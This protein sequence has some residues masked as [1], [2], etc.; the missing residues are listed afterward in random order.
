MWI[1]FLHRANRNVS[2]VFLNGEIGGWY[3]WRVKTHVPGVGPL[4]EVIEVTLECVL[5]VCGYHLT[6]NK[7]IISKKSYRGAW[8][9]RVSRYGKN[10][11]RYIAIHDNRITI[12]IAIY[13]H[14]ILL[15]KKRPNEHRNSSTC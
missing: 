10:V 5:I 14:G 11:L 1:G 12:R 9:L 13:C 6:V 7:T 4:L 8:A 15:L 3:I 2:V